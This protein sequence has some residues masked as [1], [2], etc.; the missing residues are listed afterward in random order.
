[1]DPDQ[2]NRGEGTAAP[3]ERRIKMRQYGRPLAVEPTEQSRYDARRNGGKAMASSPDISRALD[4]DIALVHKRFVRAMEQRLP[5]IP[6]DSKERY[7]AVLSALAGKLE[8]PEKPLREI[9]TE[10]MVEAGA[11][12][13]AELNS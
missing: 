10:L 3:V 12:L 2:Y 13:M 7:F 5:T 8:A 6:Q 4:K 1:M 11:H 9:L